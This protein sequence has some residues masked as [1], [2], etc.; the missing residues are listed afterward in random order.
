ME[1]L[2]MKKRSLKATAMFLAAVTL[3]TA[4][5]APGG[6]AVESGAVN[7]SG[8]TQGAADGG[9]SQASAGGMVNIEFWS[10]PQVAQQA[11]WESMASQ[12]KAVNPNV[13][14]TVSAMP[15]SP[16]S[17]AGIQSAI[18]SGT[19]PAASENV[20]RGFAAQLAEAE[21]IVPFDNFDGFDEIVA[22][23]GMTSMMDSWQFGDG[24]QYVLPMFSNPSMFLWRIDLLKEL[25]FE[26]A[27]LTYSEVYEVG[28]ALKAKY[29]D[30]FVWASN[31]FTNTSWYKRW[32][33][34]LTLYL[35]ASEGNAFIENNKLVADDE[36]A[37]AVYGFFD[38][39]NKNGYLLAQEVTDPFETGIALCTQFVP[40]RY[41]AMHEKYPDLKYGT[42]YAVASAPVPDGVPTEN[43][44]T[45]SDNK[46]VVIYSQVSKEQQEAAYDFI[47]WVYEN[48]AHDAEWMD[49]TYLLPAQDNLLDNAEFAAL[50]E[51][52][53]ELVPFAEN[54]K[55]AVPA[56][57]N[58][59]YVET[60]TALGE[61]GMVPVLNGEK[62]PQEAWADV[63]AEIETV[64]GK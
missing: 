19:A 55:N 33:D 9:G 31:A 22:S 62:A 12:Y 63:K 21:A 36:A 18:A 43:V 20:F 29:P 8:G 44:K 13:N 2:V 60:H 39:M 14:V 49:T 27:P 26:Q 35:G 61:K 54:V 1:E 28:A 48:G 53:P 64:L 59:D 30:R 58:A 3:L 15:E 4:C 10:A 38:E 47:K 40:F 24:H 11:F 45:M 46:G 6:Q 7:A 51:E 57:D 16:S 32:W 17:E 56:I 50:F 34:Y 37:V 25:G 52:S 5:G 42:E 23:R 41:K